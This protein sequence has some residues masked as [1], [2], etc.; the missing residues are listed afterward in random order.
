MSNDRSQRS[1]VLAA[2]LLAPAAL[3]DDGVAPAACSAD[4]CVVNVTDQR[5]VG[6][7]CDGQSVLLAYSTLSGAALIQ[8]SSADSP[9]ETLVLAYERQDAA[10]TSYELSGFKFVR[11]EAVGGVAAGSASDGSKLNLCQARQSRSPA[12]SG[13]LPLAEKR[14]SGESEHPYCYAIGYLIEAHGVVTLSGEAREAARPLS[15]KEAQKWA[16]LR[17]RLSRYASR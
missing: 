8:C 10:A 9:M 17:D 12:V 7:P 15:A 3:A 13:A 11:P 5:L 1:L 14:P 2:M 4:I 6:A 16:T